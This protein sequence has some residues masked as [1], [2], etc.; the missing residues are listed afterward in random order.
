MKFVASAEDIAADDYNEQEWEGLNDT[1]KVLQSF[2]ISIR[3]SAGSFKD[4]DAIFAEIGENWKTYNSVQKAAIATSVAG[5]RQREV[6]QATMENWESVSKA[7]KLAADSQ[8]SAAKKMEAYTSSIEAGT[9]RIQAAI[10]KIALNLNIEGVM[11]KF[12]SIIADLIDNLGLLSA[13]V[14][15]YL[16][17]FKGQTLYNSLL[18][19]GKI[20]TNIAFGLAKAGMGKEGEGSFFKAL[21]DGM[22]NWQTDVAAGLQERQITNNIDKIKKTSNY[23]SLSAEEQG[24][25]TNATEF[26]TRSQNKQLNAKLQE[27]SAALANETEATEELTLKKRQLA[28][29]TMATCTAHEVDTLITTNLSDEERLQIANK[30]KNDAALKNLTEAQQEEIIK[31]RQLIAAIEKRTAVLKKGGALDQTNGMFGS[32]P[33]K[34]DVNKYMLKGVLSSTGMVGGGLLGS[35]AGG[36]IGKAFGLE[37]STGSMIG[38]MGLGALGGNLG[39]L[40][41]LFSQISKNSAAG[42]KGLSKFT[43]A[44][45]AVPGALGGVVSGVAMIVAAIAAIAIK[46]KEERKQ[47]RLDEYSESKDKYNEIVGATAEYNDARYTH[48]ASGVDQ[49][50]NNISLTNEEYEEFLEM[51]NKLAETFPELVTYTDE[52]GNRFLSLG[53]A[54]NEM[55]DALDQATAAAKRKR[56]MALLEAHDD[57]YEEDRE[58]YAKL[59]QNKTVAEAALNGTLEN[60]GENRAKLRAMGITEGYGIFSGSTIKIDN[61]EA[62]SKLQEAAA[63]AAR[64]ISTLNASY[65]DSYEAQLREYY[66]YD[67]NGQ[68]IYD[69]LPD[70]IHKGIESTINSGAIRPDGNWQSAIEGVGDYYTTYGDVLS[71][72]EE[73]FGGDDA[74]GADYHE[75]RTDMKNY[76]LEQFGDVGQ[77]DNS[78]KAFMISI[79]FEIDE[80]TLTDTQDTLANIIDMKDVDGNQLGKDIVKSWNLEKYTT[81]EIKAIYSAVDNGIL[82]KYGSS[83]KDVKAY[84][85]ANI[86]GGETD[87]QLAKKKKIRENAF[88]EDKYSKLL[89]EKAKAGTKQVS[90]EEIAKAFPGLSDDMLETATQ[91]ANKY[92]KNMRIEAKKATQQNL[93]LTKSEKTL[94]GITKKLATQTKKEGNAIKAT[95]NAKKKG[96]SIDKKKENIDQNSLDNIQDRIKGEKRLG[97]TIVS[98]AKKAQK[99][100][101]VSAKAIKSQ[102]KDAADVTKTQ[103]ADAI[104]EFDMTKAQENYSKFFSDIEDTN[105]NGILDTW[106]ELA[107]G[108]E[109]VN[110]AITMTSEAMEEQNNQG[111]LSV[112]T[113]LSLLSANGEYINCLEVKNGQIMLTANAEEEMAKIQMQALQSEIQ[114][115]IATINTQI[116]KCEQILETNSAYEGEIE[117]I[118]ATVDAQSTE[119]DA[120]NQTITSSYSAA[121]ATGALQA[122]YVDTGNAAAHAATQIAAFN[123]AADGATSVSVS[124]DG[125]VKTSASADYGDAPTTE[126]TID[127]T[128]KKT[129]L[130]EDQKKQ[131]SDL[132][133]SLEDRK[134][135]LE[136]FNDSLDSVE[137][138]KESYSPSSGSSGGGGGGGD[139]YTKLDKVKDIL[140][141]INKEYQQMVAYNEKLGSGH[142]ISLSYYAKKRKYLKEEIKLLKQQAALD[143]GTKDYYT[144]IQELQQAKLDLA[145]LDNE[146]IQD[147]I[148]L[149][150]ARKEL[151]GVVTNMMVREY[152]LLIK[153]ADT[154]AQ[155]LEYEKKLADIKKEQLDTQIAISKAIRDTVAAEVVMSTAYSNNS[156]LTSS[157]TVKNSKSSNLAGLKT[158]TTKSGRNTNDV[159]VADTDKNRATLKTIEAL[160]SGDKKI[161]VAKRNKKGEIIKKNGKTQYKYVKASSVYVGVDNE[162]NLVYGAGTSTTKASSALAKALT[163]ANQSGTS[164]TYKT[165]SI[166]DS[167]GGKHTYIVSETNTKRAKRIKKLKKNYWVSIAVDDSGELHYSTKKKSTSKN[168][169]TVAKAKKKAKTSTKKKAKQ[170]V[171]DANTIDSSL[172]GHT[173]SD[174]D[175]GATSQWLNL[176]KQDLKATEYTYGNTTAELAKATKKIKEQL[177]EEAA[178]TLE[179]KAQAKTDQ[180]KLEL[181][182]EYIDLINQINKAEA[183]EAQTLLDMYDTIGLMNE[184]TVALLET[185]VKGATTLQEQWEYQVKLNDAIKEMNETLK[186]TRDFRLELLETLTEYQSYTPNTKKYEDLIKQQKEILQTELNTSL[187]Q[188][189]EYRQMAYELKREAYMEQGMSKEDATK[190]AWA[191]SENDESYQEQMRAYIEIYKKLGDLVIKE[192]EDKTSEIERRIDKLE[193]KRADEWRSTWSSEG[194]LIESATSKVKTY[195]D[196]IISLQQSVKSEALKT[197]KDTDYLTDEQVESLVEKYNSAAVAIHEAMVSQMEDTIGVQETMYDAVVGEVND[198]ITNLEKEKEIKEKMYDDEIEELQKK[199]ESMQRTN[200]LLEKEKALRD[201]LNNKQRI[202]REGIGWV[203]EAD[204][205]AVKQAQ[206]DLDSQKDTNKLDDLEKAKEEEL[207]VLD[208]KIEAWNDYLTMLETQYTSYERLERQKILMEMTGAKDVAGIHAYLEKDMETF[209]QYTKDQQ[210]SFI[211]NSI[212]AYDS[213]NSAFSTF[214]DDYEKNQLRLYQLQG[215]TKD[216]LSEQDYVK[217]MTSNGATITQALEY[218]LSNKNPKDEEKEVYDALT[219]AKYTTTDNTDSTVNEQNAALAAA[220]MREKNGEDIRIVDQNGK[221]YETASDFQKAQ[222]KDNTLQIAAY[223]SDQAKQATGHMT[224]TDALYD[225]ETG[226]AV[227]TASG[228]TLSSAIVSDAGKT[229]YAVSNGTAVTAANA[230]SITLNGDGTVTFTDAKGNTTKGTL[231]QL[232]T[233]DYAKVTNTTAKGTSLSDLYAKYGEDA[234]YAVDESGNIRYTT[235]GSY[236]EG[237]GLTTSSGKTYSGQ[238]IA[239]GDNTAVD[240]TNRTDV[241]GTTTDYASKYVYKT[242]AG[243]DILKMLAQY[244]DGNVAIVYNSDGTAKVVAG[245]N[246]SISGGTYTTGTSSSAKT[247][248]VA[249]TI[250]SGG[251][252]SQSAEVVTA[253]NAAISARTGGAADYSTTSSSGKTVDQMTAAYDNVA[254]VKDGDSVRLV[255]GNNSTIKTVTDKNGNKKQVYETAGGKQYDIVSTVEKAGKAY[256]TGINNGPVTFTGLAQLDGT[257]ANP[258][259]VLTNDQA[260][261]L[262]RNISTQKVAYESA[263]DNLINNNTCSGDTWNISEINMNEVQDVNAFFNELMRQTQQ[264]Y[265][266][267]KKK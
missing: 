122:A 9:Q 135:M 38:M 225:T 239:G 88:D 189:N 44:I 18:G 29:E 5:T 58:K 214:L 208:E 3:E 87:S 146:K 92:L 66:G 158:I 262:L 110:E 249:T 33:T 258:E 101:K 203:Y 174:Q 250:S 76:F 184:A 72:Y 63:D 128:I 73:A 194:K 240:N 81:D 234:I 45:G 67:E 179:K 201:A 91:N 254:Y 163:K 21:R 222:A 61:E 142:D 246:S 199:E 248:E 178:L 190:Q 209:T 154:E 16:A 106:S 192:F 160:R 59:R 165:A 215:E 83:A 125:S 1:E 260:Y 107:A 232:G 51:S 166:T 211:E 43:Q 176:V 139:D 111:H 130:T 32:A 144:D 151:T 84:L 182:A 80:N 193:T 171:N 164:N 48:L 28:I 265:S 205:E 74:K 251:T 4:A 2:G 127:N 42:V 50:G 123:A 37:E 60:T 56:D 213:F 150:E 100:T 89:Q 153:T 25:I 231:A 109:K 221:V 242:S 12:Y 168:K 124:E 263:I 46:V 155:R 206:R 200:D 86:I 236:T 256:A 120:I 10:E 143:K 49:Y 55:A 98:V 252:T 157:G 181:Q 35:Y 34:N 104:N 137:G 218:A 26:N 259:Y 264:Q 11:N 238:A 261:T 177:M 36:K 162:G 117:A 108:F 94:T 134:K 187:A 52:A 147:R 15:G 77:W 64:D 253:L 103:M 156:N 243:S 235:K 149:M 217:A 198:I 6:F 161:K 79:G 255:G 223:T 27:F 233:S 93:K 112:Q 266:V 247:Y 237:T 99:A 90:T 96:T 57:L 119:V 226:K 229:T 204:R 173:T 47:A 180:E 17:L 131:V 202:Y 53:T 183:E 244:E 39:T 126:N 245:N 227:T 219:G 140:A 13:A 152:N 8:G 159:E 19:G 68:S 185:Q 172:D 22:E 113:V 71:Q 41:D 207:K 62:R 188:A 267:R 230:K 7:A 197:L 23:S 170:L 78:Q 175:N 115:Q 30:V 257:P 132:K 167:W 138:F 136:T 20:G 105:G 191:D 69:N 195:Y 54:A 169:K 85:N 196:S 141:T 212:K 148:D 40:S 145:A 220:I 24:I 102:A 210:E 65:I 121:S 228:Q 186:N 241:T 129:E 216:L 133:K 116:A 118:S 70:Y 75:Y 31:E 114:Y 14:V 95:I 97:N 224:N 82:T